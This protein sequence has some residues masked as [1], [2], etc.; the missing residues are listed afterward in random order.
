MN[1][2]QKIKA[3]IWALRIIVYAICA[4]IGFSLGQSC[5]NEDANTKQ[6]ESLNHL[7]HN[8]AERRTD[9]AQNVFDSI[10]ASLTTASAN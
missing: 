9:A 1:E 8:P 5:T 10:P 4:Y 2:M 7:L 6:D 3:D